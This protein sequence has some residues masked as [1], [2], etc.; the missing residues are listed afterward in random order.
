MVGTTGTVAF[1]SDLASFAAMER[2]LRDHVK[3]LV[4]ELHDSFRLERYSPGISRSRIL[5]FVEDLG[6]SIFHIAGL[7]MPVQFARDE[8]FTY[9]PLKNG[10]SPELFFDRCDSII[11][12]LAIKSPDIEPLLGPSVDD[13][14]F[15]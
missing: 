2:V 7:E 4:L 11:F 14:L 3:Y 8:G 13:P 9:R 1:R 10:G 6:F 12:L 15:F 5:R